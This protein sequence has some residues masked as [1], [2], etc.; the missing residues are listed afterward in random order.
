MGPA[1]WISHGGHQ[2]RR[3][4]LCACQAD[5]PCCRSAPDDAGT[6]ARASGCS[7]ERTAQKG[8]LIRKWPR[9][10]DG[11]AGWKQNSLMVRHGATFD[12]QSDEVL[13][14]ARMEYPID[15]GPEATVL[16]DMALQR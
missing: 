6:R 2:L 10:G 8:H 7:R 9:G 11:S 13:C 5:G 16:G 15:N 14:V 12:H 3:S 4:P 1:C